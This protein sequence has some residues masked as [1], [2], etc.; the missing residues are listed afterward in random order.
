MAGRRIHCRRRRQLARLRAAVGGAAQFAA[1][2]AAA[3]NHP[4]PVV[5]GRA[6]AAEVIAG[7]AAAKKCRCRLNVG[8]PCPAPEDL[9]RQQDYCSVVDIASLRAAGLP[10]R[11]TRMLRDAVNPVAAR[12]TVWGLKGRSGRW[13]DRSR[14]Q[15]C[16]HPE[17]LRSVV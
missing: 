1:A 9:S 5:P 6:V 3:P 14:H 12:M 4:G 17:F 13:R 8:A 16:L 11:R 2:A 15:I 10:S 7:V